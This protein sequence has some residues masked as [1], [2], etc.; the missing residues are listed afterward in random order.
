MEV[1]WRR[2]QAS[3][4]LKKK[5]HHAKTNRSANDE[6]THNGGGEVCSQERVWHGTMVKKTTFY[7]AAKKKQK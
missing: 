1:G 6:R 2:K 5:E 7:Q 4:P 3:S